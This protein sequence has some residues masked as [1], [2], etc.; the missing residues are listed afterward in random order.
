ME[1]LKF[2]IDYGIVGFLVFLSMISLAIAIERWIAYRRIR[3]GDFAKK[4]ELELFLT[5]KIHIIA[6]I[7]SNAPYIGLLGPWLLPFEVASVVLLAT[8]IG[9]IVVA[10][11]E[12]KDD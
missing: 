11:K 1:W 9:A 3:P 7:G 10:R 4:K 2:A 8:L 12:I 6:T 5:S